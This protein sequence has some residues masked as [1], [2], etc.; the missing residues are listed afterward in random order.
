VKIEMERT[1]GDDAELSLE[2]RDRLKKRL[3]AERDAIG[4]RLAARRRTLLDGAERAPDEADFASD[5]ADQGLVVRLIDRDAKLLR[6]VEAA[7]HRMAIGTY[8]VCT[9][10]GEPIGFERLNSRPWTRHA[11][12]A[13]EDVE[14]RQAHM[15][16]K[17]A[18]G[19]PTESEPMPK[20]DEAA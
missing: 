12:E 15:K 1:V 7:L 19:F 8:G 10:S 16:T 13:K 9:L 6:E 11:L 2:Q 20:N 17:V 14:R 4:Q 3:L 5:S 18:T